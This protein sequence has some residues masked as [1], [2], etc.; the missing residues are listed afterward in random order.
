MAT[1]DEMTNDEREFAASWGDEE[2]DGGARPDAAAAGGSTNEAP[3]VAEAANAAG[4]KAEARGASVKQETNPAAESGA[5]GGGDGAAGNPSDIANPD[6]EAGAVSAGGE[7]SGSDGPADPKEQQQ[8]RSWRG[9]L[10]KREKDIADR[11]A[12]LKEAEAKLSKDPEKAG[13]ALE[14]VAENAEAKGN[15]ALAEKAEQLSEQVEDGSISV[16]D[17]MARL[18]EDF[19]SDFVNMMTVVFRDIAAQEADRISDGKVSDKFGQLEQRTMEGFRSIGERHMML[20]REKID[21]AVPGF[22]KLIENP[23]FQ[24]FMASYPD[25]EQIGSGGTARQII[26]ML[27][28]FESAEGNSEGDGTQVA[29]KNQTSRE[30]ESVIAQAKPSEA[31]I[32]AAAGVRTGGAARVPDAP[33]ESSDYAGAWGQA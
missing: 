21:D 26:K 20:H 5:V 23:K 10:D 14:K 4:G 29:G 15:E 17:A 19:G 3:G 22:E 9:R 32:D 18:S 2:G 27:K 24:E 7:G 12:R 6:A 8:E 16:K 31:A 1:K 33:S 13:D 30:V 28:A 11:E 25:G